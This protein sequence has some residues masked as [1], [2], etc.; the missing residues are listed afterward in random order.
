[1]LFVFPF[2]F[3]LFFSWLFVFPFLF[4]FFAFCLS[5]CSF[6]PFILLLCFLDFADLLFGF[7]FAF[8]VFLALFFSSFKKVRITYGLADINKDVATFF[9]TAYY[10][11][12]DSFLKPSIKI[13]LDNCNASECT[14]LSSSSA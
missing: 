12:S 8:C 1:M 6:F 10:S 14:E 9:I 5:F 13:K 4:C 11:K 2:L 7:S 3:L